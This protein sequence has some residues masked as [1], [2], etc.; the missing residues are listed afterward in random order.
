MKERDDQELRFVVSLLSPFGKS[1][2]KKTDFSILNE[3]KLI[4]ILIKNKIIRKFGAKLREE[5]EF[6]R[7][8][9]SRFDKVNK[10]LLEIEA[11][12]EKSLDEFI[13]ISQK[14]AKQNIHLLLTKS[15]GEFPH[16]SSNI[17]CL[18]EP[19]K[20]AHT[21]KVL[22]EEGYQEYPS[23]REPH[24]F[25]FRK[26]IAPKELPLHIHTRVE[27]EAVEFANL[28]NLRGRARFLLNQDTGALIPSV[29]DAI[30][31]TIAHYFFEDHEIRI[32]D[33]LNLCA[34]SCKRID[35]HYIIS[36][37]QALGWENALSLNLRLL[38]EM[39]KHYFNKG[40][41]PELKKKHFLKNLNF[42]TNPNQ[43][44]VLK[45][46]YMVSAGFFLQK[47]LSNM[48]C[49]AHEKTK[50]M[51]YVCSDVIGRKILGYDELK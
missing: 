26:K 34:V 17:D 41:F 29:E 46:P 6:Q 32:N 42:I 23:V 2:P 35:W 44:G 33:L 12:Q 36:E 9:F 39:S 25:L 4:K 49:S 21:I 47:I 19:D 7:S 24:K 10:L 48:N 13:K 11:A 18:I 37:A 43:Y 38:N 27:W 51:V 50:Q 20:L 5:P 28:Y 14:L 22:Q 1:F 30:L 8:F 45:I 40:L 15:T 16:E 3:Q 31:I